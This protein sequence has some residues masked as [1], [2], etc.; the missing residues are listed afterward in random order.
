MAA[1]KNFRHELFCQT[2]MTSPKPY[3]RYNATKS[4]RLIYPKGSNK[5]AM[6]NGPRLRAKLQFRLSEIWEELSKLQGG[7]QLTDYRRGVVKRYAPK[8]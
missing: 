5:T 6:T 1:L 2:Y 3:V 7:Y 8:S 4:Y